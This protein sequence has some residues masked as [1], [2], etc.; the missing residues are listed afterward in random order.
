MPAVFEE[1]PMGWE[2]LVVLHFAHHGEVAAVEVEVEVEVAVPQQL[3]LVLQL[4]LAHFAL[5]EF[6]LMQQNLF[7]VLLTLL[8]LTS[9]LRPTLETT[10]VA[11][12]PTYYLRIP[13]SNTK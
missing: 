7:L 8:V 2:V 13:Y 5:V 6:Q 12:H 11:F 10:W 4:L 1:C 3:V 9:S